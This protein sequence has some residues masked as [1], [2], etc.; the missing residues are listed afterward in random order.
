MPARIVVAHYDS[1]EALRLAERVTRE[2]FQGEPYVY[3]GSKGFRWLRENPPAAVLIDLTAMP[4]YGKYLGCMLREQKGT[5]SIP[6]VFLNGDPQKTAQIKTLL[7]DATFTSLPR[8]AAAIQKTVTRPPANPVIPK[9]DQLAASKLKIR[10]GSVVA[11]IGA[12]KEVKSSL[13]P[14][15]AGVRFQT[16]EA[17]AD[18][19]VTF[20]KS[21][22]SLGRELPALA[23]QP[24]AGRAIWIAW[25]KKASESAGDLT[26]PRIV[27]MCA[28]YGLAAYKSCAV[29]ETWSA[30]VI[31]PKRK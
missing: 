2:G 31:A 19:V 22:A 17:G 25:P 12:P 5:R 7:P 18:V 20:V 4:S 24:R 14:L 8:L 27:E 21:V 15:P 10:E 13:K 11:L 6:I 9:S 29:D 28:A 26:M 1:A 23:G 3:R 16:K 30:V